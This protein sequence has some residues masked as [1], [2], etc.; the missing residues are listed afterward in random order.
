M[1]RKG[2]GGEGG[3]VVV[4]GASSVSMNTSFYKLL[5]YSGCHNTQPFITAATKP[6]SQIFFYPRFTFGTTEV[7][8]DQP[9][10]EEKLL[11]P[12]QKLNVDSESNQF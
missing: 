2:G 8:G 1:G 4:P 11:F 12:T 7:P 10:K 9:L 3:V 6:T 5:I